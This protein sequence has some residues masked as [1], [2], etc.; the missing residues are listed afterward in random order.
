MKKQILAALAATML[1]VGLATTTKAATAE[2]YFTFSAW[3]IS[4]YDAVWWGT[5]VV[6]PSTIWGEAVTS[7]WANA[8]RAKG[9][10]SVVIPDSVTS[11]WITAFFENNLTSI[12]I[13]DSVT[14]IWTEAFRTNNLTSLVL[15][16]WLTSIWAHAF[17]SND[18]T[19]VTIPDSITI[20]EATVFY[21]NALTSITI[22]D[23][24]TSIWVNAFTVQTSSAWNGTVT[25]PSSWYVFDLYAN[26]TS[27]YF[28][29]AKLPN[30]ALS[31]PPINWTCWSD[32]WSTVAAQPSSDLCSAWT[33]AWTDS[34]WS[35]WAYNWSCEWTNWWTNASC[36]AAVDTWW[37][38]CWSWT[39][40]DADANT[41]N[42]VAIW[43]QC[44]M[45]SNL[46]VWT[47]VDAWVSV[48]T[49]DS[50]IEKFC[51]NNV[52]SGCDSYWALYEWNE[53]MQYSNEES[54]QWICPINWHIPSD[55]EYYLLENYLDSTVN[56][57]DLEGYRWINIWTQLKTG[58]TSGFDVVFSWMKYTSWFMHVGTRW[59]LWSSTENGVNAYRRFIE[60]TDTSYRGLFSKDR[61]LSIRCI[62]DFWL[63]AS[64]SNFA[65][66]ASSPAISWSKLQWSTV[67]ANFTYTDADWDTAWA[68]TYQWKW[69]A[70]H[71]WTYSNIAWATSS[72]YT[73]V[74]D[75]DK[76][77]LK[78]VIT[79][80]AATWDSPWLSISSSSFW[81]VLWSES[82]EDM[83]TDLSGTTDID[84]STLVTSWWWSSSEWALALPA[85]T[86]VLTLAPEQKLNVTNSID[87]ATDAT[88]VTVPWWW[89][90]TVKDAIEAIMWAAL[91]WDNVDSVQMDSWIQWE[92]IVLA[93]TDGSSVEIADETTIY[94]PPEW[95]WTISPP[96]VSSTPPPPPSWDVE[97]AWAV[98][99]WAPWIS[100]VFDKAA[101]LTL[102]WWWTDVYYSIDWSTWH[103][104]TDECADLN[105]TWLVFP[106]E[107][108][109][110]S[111][112]TTIVWTYHFTEFWVFIPSEAWWNVNTLTQLEII[113]WEVTID[114]PSLL[115]FWTW[116]VASSTQTVVLDMTTYSGWSL[117]FDLQDL[118][119]AASW[120]YTTLDIWHLTVTWTSKQI[121]NTNV[122]I[123]LTWDNSDITVRDWLRWTWTW[124]TNWFQNLPPEIEIPSWTPITHIKIDDPLTVLRRDSATTPDASIL[125]KYWLQPKFEIEIPKYQEIG[126]YD[127]VMTY[128]LI[129][130]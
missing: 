64:P 106:W 107:C 120:Y 8:F 113:A 117:Y 39:V 38:T 37:F 12:V 91:W 130:Q 94:A 102:P 22:P 30:Y 115:D 47:R 92:P 56:D 41:Y 83:A 15:S 7:I 49:D 23:S 34:D 59:N 108:Y 44:W 85:N 40:D 126:E 119:W 35:D 52:D 63:T 80:V 79:P 2:Q 129:E 9:L 116:K 46:N 68:H 45:A 125:W 123:T 21:D 19:T 48:M 69:S 27:T 101:K 57:P 42:T 62:S 32:D 33:L 103:H 6:I 3:N 87:A 96:Q 4:A 95:D 58:G 112:D 84:F 76:K 111:W 24:V 53:A 17:R 20:I 90:T 81:P 73:T 55:W 25:W 29:K 78:V 72:T 128:T 70:T 16:N 109:I 10:T 28:D 1:I 54:S 114:A 97:S 18:L 61:G 104:I 82:N 110:Q 118:K 5:D 13:P 124:Y 50:I 26:D 98:S 122:F 121:D 36:S 88:L 71:N 93:S 75:A 127:A 74:S 100:L 105:W 77:Y 43:D 51:N 67:S 11:I 31:N 66:V 60:S 89:A 99:V 14:S 65:P 86:V